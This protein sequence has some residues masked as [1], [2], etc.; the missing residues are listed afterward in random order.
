MR[1]RQLAGVALVLAGALLLM[2]S[3]IAGW[4]SSNGV[5]LSG[6]ALIILGIILHVRL[7]KSGQKY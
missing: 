1:R 2:V 6:L 3:F 7:A 4:T 5:L